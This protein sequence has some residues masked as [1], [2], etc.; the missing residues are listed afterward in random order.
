MML[1][2]CACCTNKVANWVCAFGTFALFPISLMPLT[3]VAMLFDAVLSAAVLSA[4]MLSEFEFV[5]FKVNKSVFRLAIN[6]AQ[7]CDKFNCIWPAK[8]NAVCTISR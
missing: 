7:R 8:Y 6:N 3:A 4:A 2:F 1:S 5:G